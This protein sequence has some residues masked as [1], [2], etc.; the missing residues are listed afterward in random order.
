MTHESQ[1]D[2]MNGFFRTNGYE[3]I[4]AEENYPASKVV[5]SF[6]V[7]DDYLFEYALPVLNG[8]AESYKPFFATILTI[9]NH[10]P[11]VLP[12]WFKAKN[13]EMEYA[14]VE[15]ADHC[16]AEFF[17]KAQTEP[18]FNETIFVFMGDHGKVV[19]NSMSEMP[20]SYNHVP[21]MIYYNGV[22]PREMCGFAGQMDV[23]PTLLD[24]LGVEHKNSSFGLDLMQVEREQI[25]YTSDNAIGAR[26]SNRLYIYMPQGEKELYYN[27]TEQGIVPVIQSDSAFSEL[28]RYGLSM[29]QATEDYMKAKRAEIYEQ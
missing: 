15:Y 11:Y 5:N 27:L 29:I 12:D 10:P 14:I 17:K 24:I 2:N 9:S 20:E 18:W 3:D 23:T 22:E 8:Y 6:G 1:Y 19:G 4:Y 13:S 16:I 26:D 28:K 25:F 21:F 7:A